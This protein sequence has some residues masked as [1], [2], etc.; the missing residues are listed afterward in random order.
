MRQEYPS[1]RGQKGPF[2]SAALLFELRSCSN[3]GEQAE[4]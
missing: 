3:F 1:G 2:P 4:P